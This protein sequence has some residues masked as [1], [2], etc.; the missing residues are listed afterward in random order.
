MF[1]NFFKKMFSKEDEKNLREQIGPAVT[2]IA[3]G[4]EIKGTIK[5]RDT[6]RVSG[7]FE[8]NINCARMVWIDHSGRIDGNIHASRIINEGE[9]N[10]N[11]DSAEKVEIRSS[12]RMIGN[13]NASKIIIA[14]GCF[15][16]GEAHILEK[17]NPTGS[18][19]GHG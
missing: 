6:M 15:F 1:F 17:D 3:P 8:G 5:G 9:L 2:V 16:D 4:T 14:Q 10:G 11:I 19:E 7:Y 13:I 12:G 18:V